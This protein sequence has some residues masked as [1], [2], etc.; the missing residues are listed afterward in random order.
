MARGTVAEFIVN[1]LAAWGVRRIYGLPG[2]SI[3][4]L[5]DAVRKS[6]DIDFYVCRHEET[7]AFMA[8]AQAK[9]TGEMGVCLADGGPGAVHLTNGL[10]DAMTDH[11][12]LL[13]LTGQN[14]ERQIGTDAI[15]YTDQNSLFAGA[16]GLTVTITSAEQAQPV[17][18]AAV[19]LAYC[20][21]VPV[22]LAVAQDIQAQPALAAVNPKSVVLGAVPRLDEA[23]LDQAAELLAAA[24]RPM[25]LAGRPIRGQSGPV[26][27]LA[28]TLGAGLVNTLPAKGALP[29]SDGMVLGCLGSAGN[30][31]SR[32]MMAQADVVLILGSTWWPA[33][34]VPKKA[35]VVQVDL[36]PERIG[37]KAP[38]EV[39]LVGDVRDVVP[40]LAGRL[41]RRGKE[42]ANGWAAKV[43]EAIKRRDAWIDKAAQAGGLPVHPARLVRAI[44]QAVAPDA[45]LAIDTGDHTQWFGAHFRAERQ[46]VLLSGMWRTMG[47]GLGA[48]MAA[49]IARPERQVL[50]LVGD[51]GF[52]MTLAD[53]ATAVKYGL[54]ITIVV[55]DNGLYALEANKQANGNYP[56]FG[57]E[58]VNPDFAA[59]AVSM[60]AEGRR[61]ERPEDL[62]GLLEEGLSSE[63]P[64]LLDV[65]VAPV[66]PPELGAGK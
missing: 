46:D 33:K 26:L 6:A 54:A 25:I 18:E 30:A 51:G 4:G 5:L 41:A 27:A 17:L 56:V 61:L 49:K 32:E 34:Y 1:Q 38:V 10:Y 43:S 44:E 64:F 37:D 60:G 66:P 23:L 24:R 20:S 28:R 58:F 52:G 31:A 50:G 59:V 16:S 21:G 7:A 36:K 53:L 48:A 13:A 39:G 55:A 63:K 14:P 35:R 3:L 45:I 8:S 2:S 11:V 9:L 22:H 57:E 62:P 12:P 47:F 19:K 40:A 29:E 15:Q 42:P 65:P